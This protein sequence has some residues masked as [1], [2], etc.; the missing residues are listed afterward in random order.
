MKLEP[1]E[2]SFEKHSII[3]FHVNLSNESRV[4][5]R[6]HRDRYDDANSS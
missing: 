6:E 1:S 5:P 2:Q 4:I 3:K